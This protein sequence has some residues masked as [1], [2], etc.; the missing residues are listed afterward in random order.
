ATGKKVTVLQHVIET[1]KFQNVVAVHG[2]AEE[3]V[4]KPEYRAA[5]DV[6]T[7]RDVASL[8]VLLEYAAPFSRVGGTIIFPKK[9]DLADE[10]AQGKRAA[11]QVGAGLKGDIPMT[12][13]GL[14]DGRRLLVW[15]QG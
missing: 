1:L 5:F 11:L 7:A 14:E 9:G 2:R 6:V 13:S 10:F 3:L 15:K 8:P 4:H 12:L